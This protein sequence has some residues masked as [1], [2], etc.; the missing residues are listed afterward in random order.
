MDQDVF[1]VIFLEMTFFCIDDTA[2]Q[3]LLGVSDTDRPPMSSVVEIEK[4]SNL[5]CVVLPYPCN[6]E[7]IDTF[8]KFSVDVRDCLFP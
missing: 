5:S 3:R 4:F 2:T 1:L 8:E 7:N 6:D